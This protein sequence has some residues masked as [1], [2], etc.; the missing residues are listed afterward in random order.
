MVAKSIFTTIEETSNAY[1][2]DNIFPK[3]ITVVTKMLVYGDG[4]SKVVSN[5][6]TVSGVK[7]KKKAV[8]VKDTVVDDEVLM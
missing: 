4:S 7:S 5:W 2:G 6:A 8:V 1:K 3:E